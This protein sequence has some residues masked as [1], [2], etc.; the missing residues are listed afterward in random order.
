ME[1]DDRKTEE[2]QRALRKD[3]DEEA[4]GWMYSTSRQELR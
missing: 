3:E 4:V 1:E 2:K